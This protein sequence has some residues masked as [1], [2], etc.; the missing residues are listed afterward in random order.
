M[1]VV[2]IDKKILQEAYD[3][4]AVYFGLSVPLIGE[5]DEYNVAEGRFLRAMQE[6]RA[7]ADLDRPPEVQA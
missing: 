4:G 2:T 3:A 6:L 5:E 7:K 1:D